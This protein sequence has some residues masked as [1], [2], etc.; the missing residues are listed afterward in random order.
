MSG[1]FDDA[2]ER[3]QSSM[4]RLEAVGLSVTV[5]ILQMYR[6]FVELL[7]GTPGRATQSVTEAY[8]VLERTGERRRLATTAALLGRLLYAQS[9]FEE[10]DR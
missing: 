2:R 5:A 10:S 8:A 3:W 7:A 4:G 6:V 9:S 1:R